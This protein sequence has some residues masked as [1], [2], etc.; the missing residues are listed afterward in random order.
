MQQAAK[1]GDP[2]A[3]NYL[4]DMYFDGNIVERDY[5]KAAEWYEEAVRNGSPLGHFNLGILYRYGLG[6]RFDVEKMFHHRKQAYAANVSAAAYYLGLSYSAGK[7]I[8]T[9]QAEKY[10]E[11]AK[12]NGTIQYLTALAEKGHAKEQALL[13][14]IYSTGELGQDY[15]LALKWLRL[16]AESGNPIAQNCLGI[17]YKNGKGV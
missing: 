14:V 8:D 17:V 3:A 10:F 4:G 1:N 2:L 7:D 5:T 16:S 12:R 6:V 15:E 11:E 9:V 13:G